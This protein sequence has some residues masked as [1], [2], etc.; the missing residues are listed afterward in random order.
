MEDNRPAAL[1]R[2]RLLLPELATLLMGAGVLAL[3]SFTGLLE[4][5]LAG[6]ASTIVLGLILLGSYDRPR[7]LEINV[8]IDRSRPET[9]AAEG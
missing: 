4:W 1:N 6:S 2:L 7:A 3:L 5:L 8:P 9:E